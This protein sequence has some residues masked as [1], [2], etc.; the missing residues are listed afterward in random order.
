MTEAVELDRAEFFADIGYTPHAGQWKMHKSDA[1]FRVEAC[2]TRWGKTT[3]AAHESLALALEP[4]ERACGWICGPTYDL[5][6]KVWREVVYVLQ[7]RLP[8]LIQEHK[9]NEKLLRVMTMSGGSC[10]IRRKSADSPVSLLG[11]GLD[12]LVLDEA[13]QVKPDIWERY[14]LARLLDKKGRAILISTPKGKGWF[15]SAWRR[16]QE[17][18]GGYESWNGPTSENP[19]I[20]REELEL[21]RTGIP[22]LVYRQEYLAEFI[23]GAG[24][25]FRRVRDIATGKWAEPIT[26]ESYWAGLDLAKTQD[27]TVLTILDSQRRVVY[28]DRFHRVDWSVQVPRIATA[29]ARYNDAW[30]VIDS[31]GAGEPI[32]E[33]LREAGMRCEGYSFTQASKAALVNG[34]AMMLEQ[35]QITLPRPELAPELIAELEAF[36]YSVTEGGTV[37]TG[38]PPGMHDD[39]A[40]SLMLAA[41]GARD[42]GEIEVYEV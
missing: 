40:V 38:A 23:E 32:F 26:G 14:L 27:Y 5:A 30:T 31:T 12:W 28:S 17:R 25:V 39:C 3:A 42:G 37:R 34:L 4:K 36:E 22:D 10:E 29:V 2:G 16:G 19:I 9:E 13:A 35:G 33:R 8:F 15:Y 7:S 21:R 1:R 18:E 6:E 41:W 11:E 24:V 20:S